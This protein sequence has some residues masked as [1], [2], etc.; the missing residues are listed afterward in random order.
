MNDD[1]VS[2]SADQS[3]ASLD[4][5][6]GIIEYQ[7]LNLL[8][9]ASG[10]GKTCLLSWLLK[11]IRDGQPVFGTPT[12]PPPK[13]GY[14]CADRSVR[15]ARYWLAKAGYTGL[16]LYSMVEDH[17]FQPARLRSK[18]Q[19]TSI[20]GESLDKLNLPPGGLAVVDPLALFLGGN[21]NDYQ[22][23]AVAC[24]EI[25]RECRKRQI[26]LIGTAHAS[27]Q[28]S[29]KKERYQR[30][31]DRINGSG[32]QLGYGDTQMYLASPEETGDKH[33]TFLWH[34]HSSPPAVFPLGRNAEGM[35]VPWAESQEAVQENVV[36][37]TIPADGTP[38]AFAAILTLCSA[39]SRA[40][41]FR[42]LNELLA[43]GLIE[44]PAEGLYKRSKVN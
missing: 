30:L 28:K 15:T 26:T 9:G 35:F 14:V 27:K 7:S 25:R 34:P 31:Q 10:V 41:V 36:Y 1:R 2:E 16:T 8:A 40:T 43:D 11:Q 29:D 23:C 20:L 32:A 39:I 24:L 37:D 38:I 5:I 44:K 6:P 18:M 12:Q 19:L 13:I 42:R 3:Q 22:A 4:P 33:Y 21:L 17:L